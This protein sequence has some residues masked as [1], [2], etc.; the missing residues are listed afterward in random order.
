MTNFKPVNYRQ[1]D[2]ATPFGIFQAAISQYLGGRIALLQPVE[3]VSTDGKFANVRPLIA[4]YDTL[5]NPIPIT[6]A[7]VIPNIP[8]VQ[9][10]GSNG[11]FQFKPE[12]GDKGLLIACNWDTTKYKDEHAQTTVG[13]NRQFNWSDGFFIPVDF[14]SAPTGALIKNGSSEIALEK[15]EINVKTGT[16]KATAATEITGDVTITGNITVTGTI[17]ATGE[18]TGNGIALSTHTHLV[19]A[20]AALTPPPAPTPESGTPIPG[21]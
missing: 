13:S 4:H 18:I 19:P 5:G 11:Q 10:F 16:L 6:S 14:Q 12:A 20:A 2:L 15:N 17:T 8:V 21:V 3:I 1:S 9:P 7:D